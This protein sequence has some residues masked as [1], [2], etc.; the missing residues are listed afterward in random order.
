MRIHPEVSDALA[1]GRPVVALESTIISHGLP[2]P[3][4]LRVAREIEDA[5]RAGGAVPATIAI[6]G[7]EPH[8]G[9]DDAAMRRIAEGNAVVKAGVRD[10]AVLAARCGD[11]A[12]TVASTAHLAKAAGITVFAT[13]GLGGVHRGARDSWDESADL[14]TLARTGVLVVCAGV[15]SILD[16]AA[17][18]ERLE[19]LNVGVIGY[20]TDRF[21]G[22]YLAD[23]G[24]PV[25]WRV[26]TPAQVAD[27]LRA[28]RRLGTDGYGLVLANPI[29]PAD[30]MD[31][32]LHDQVLAAAL[33][34]A[35]T[36]GVRGKDV[37]PFLLDFFHRETHGASVAANIA[38][39]LSNARLAAEVAVAYTAGQAKM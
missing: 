15:K 39:V 31:R 32:A 4:N 22:F 12:T 21:P 38:L 37:T 18:L 20:R 29:A 30:E 9:L 26:E 6:V 16:V 35:E 33:A 2:R 19:T 24:H 14:M 7:G 5:V 34:A 10:V 11:G 3:D 25:G 27:V 28:S 1:A 8:V 23:S 17:T 13:G 36:Q